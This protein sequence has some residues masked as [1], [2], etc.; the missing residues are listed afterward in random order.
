MLYFSSS[1][2]QRSNRISLFFSLQFFPFSHLE[3]NIRI[4]FFKFSCRHSALYLKLH[5][6]GFT[7]IICPAHS[8]ITTYL[9]FFYIYITNFQEDR[10]KLCSFSCLERRTWAHRGNFFHSIIIFNYSLPWLIFGWILS[11]LNQAGKG[12]NPIYT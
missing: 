8:L 5:L 6:A 7:I 12:S 3:G 1:R 2:G 11:I 9:D 10:F 4:S